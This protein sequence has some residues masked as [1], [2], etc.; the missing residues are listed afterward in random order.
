MVAVTSK[1]SLVCPVDDSFTTILAR[2]VTEAS[3]VICEC[4][5]MLVSCLSLKLSDGVALLVCS[6]GNVSVMATG[7]AVRVVLLSAL[8]VTLCVSED[9]VRFGEREYSVKNFEPSL[10]IVV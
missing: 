2:D 9:D 3:D 10:L 8:I 6:G 1:I 7:V 4:D 5:V